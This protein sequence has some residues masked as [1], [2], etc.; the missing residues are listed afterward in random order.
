M[1]WA[2][3]LCGAFSG[4]TVAHVLTPTELLKCR[5]QIDRGDKNPKYKGPMDCLTQTVRQEGPKALFGIPGN[6]AWFGA[7]EG[8]IRLQTP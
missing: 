1:H 7:Y 4:A 2:V 5:L 8:I 3:L 6:I